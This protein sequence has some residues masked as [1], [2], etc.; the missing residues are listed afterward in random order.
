MNRYKNEKKYKK[1][2]VTDIANKVFTLSP[3]FVRR[4]AQSANSVTA[5]KYTL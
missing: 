2:I 3:S 4:K 1:N 5:Q